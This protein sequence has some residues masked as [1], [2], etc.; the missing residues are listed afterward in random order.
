[1]S[2]KKISHILQINIFTAIQLNFSNSMPDLSRPNI[3]Q[4]IIRFSNLFSLK[5]VQLLAVISYKGIFDSAFSI[6]R[7]TC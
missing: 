7:T 6:F 4:E 1:M 3:A 5:S 2:I